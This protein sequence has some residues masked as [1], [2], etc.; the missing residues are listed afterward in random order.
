MRRD[1]KLFGAPLIPDI[2]APVSLD[3]IPTP[4]IDAAT[5]AALK[6]QLLLLE[7]SRLQKNRKIGKLAISEERLRKTIEI[8]LQRQH[9]YPSDMNHVLEA[10]QLRGEDKRGNVLF[11]GYFTPVVPVKEKQQAPYLYPIYD[12]PRNWSGPYPSRRQIEAEHALAGKGLEL[13]YAKDP[14]DIY[15]MQIQGSG[16][17]EY[18]SGKRKYLAYNG[19]NKHP[20]RSIEAIIRNHPDGED[21]ILSPQGMR[22]FFNSNPHLK[23]SLLHRN[24]SYTFFSASDKAPEGAGGVPLTGFRSIAVDTRYIPLGACLLAAL[25]DYQAASQTVKHRYV[26]LVA[27]DTGGGIRGPGHIDLYTGTGDDAGN[28]ASR[29]R[30][31]GRLWLLLPANT[32][33]PPYIP[34]KQPI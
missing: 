20:F 27:Q 31:Y 29:I 24:P 5:T 18:P 3:S 13:A 1:G 21:A 9:G 26:L 16:F 17:V 23:D 2:Y 8:L 30:H 25:P 32:S 7:Q 11:T 12:R 4:L 6:Q 14:V 15:F 28:R 10:W 19:T 33:K 34:G 22:K